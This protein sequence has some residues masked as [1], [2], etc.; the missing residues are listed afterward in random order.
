MDFILYC[1]AALSLIRKITSLLLIFS[2]RM[3]QAVPH[4]HNTIA[5]KYF[6]L[7][8]FFFRNLDFSVFYI[9]FF[10]NKK[11][12][13]IRNIYKYS[14]NESFIIQ[15]LNK[16]NCPSFKIIIIC[17]SFVLSNWMDKDCPLMLKYYILF[18]F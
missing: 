3:F 6:Q 16:K 8:F 17:S 2:F 1:T 9:F 5:L 10:K 12:V 11:F 15:L 14:L 13:K 7:H 18:R 4:I